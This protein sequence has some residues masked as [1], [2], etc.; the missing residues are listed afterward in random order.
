MREIADLKSR[1]VFSF[2]RGSLGGKVIIVVSF[3][4][5]TI[6]PG[7]EALRESRNETRL[8]GAS[9]STAAVIFLDDSPWGSQP[10]PV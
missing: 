4:I 9:K 1:F 5:D 6:D 7:I 2:S 3:G 10:R 8:S